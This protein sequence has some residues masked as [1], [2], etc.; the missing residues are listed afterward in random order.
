VRRV[1][2]LL[3]ALLAT[4]AFIVA[5][6]TPAGAGQPPA[7]TVTRLAETIPNYFVA[8]PR[9]S[10]P[11]ASHNSFIRVAAD[12]ARNLFFELD[13]D[14]CAVSS[15]FKTNA[16]AYDLSTYRVVA[17][18][19]VDG[20]P[21]GTKAA[22]GA[23]LRYQPSAGAGDG[24]G[25][26]VAVDPVDRL[27][28][29]TASDNSITN[30]APPQV[31]VYSEDT[32]ELLD[33]WDLPAGAPTKLAG[34]SWYAPG[35][36]LVV[37]TAWDTQ[38]RAHPDG[39]VQVFDYHI[40]TTMKR[41]GA[42]TPR[43]SVGVNGCV[44][45]IYTEMSSVDAH[46]SERSLAL[47]VPCELGYSGQAG[48]TSS[49]VLATRQGV[50]TVK[51]GA[52][53]ADGTPCPGPWV[54]PVGGPAGDSVAVAPA[55]FQG[56]K[57]DPASDRAFAPNNA[58]TTGITTLVYDGRI[59]EFLG[60]TSIGTVDDL[61][62]ASLGLDTETGRLYGAGWSGLTLVD[63][64]RTPPAAG[65]VY[66]K[67]N[68][69]PQRIDVLAVPPGPGHPYTRV[70]VPFSDCATSAS[71]GCAF[72]KVAVFA[73][74]FPLTSDPPPSALDASTYGGPIEGREVTRS[75]SG[76][77]AGYGVHTDW[78]GSAN[79]ALGNATA[80]QDEVERHDLPFGAGNRDLL[81][82]NVDHIGLEDGGAKGSAAALADGQGS[83]AA[84][85]KKRTGRIWPYPVAACGFPGLVGH[86]EVTGLQDGEDSHK[87]APV[88]HSEDT[89]AA[90]AHVVC[91]EVHPH[92][93]A[94]A[95]AYHQGGTFTA[96]NG[97]AV[98][99]ARA[100]TTATV[101][102]PVGAAG[103][104]TDVT[105]TV[106]GLRIDL[107]DIGEITIGELTHH[108]RATATGRPGGA[109]TERTQPKLRDV[110]VTV[111]GTRVPL[112]MDGC[113][114]Y[115][116]V[117]DRINAT[118]PAYLKIFQPQPDPV[119]AK[120]SPGGYTSA[121]QS[122]PSAIYGDMQF[123]QMTPAE[124][125]ILPA[126]RIVVYNDGD[127]GSR[128]VVDLAGVLADAQQGV[129]PLPEF[130]H[131]DP[132]HPPVDVVKARDYA[133]P[134]P[135]AGF[136]MPGGDGT[137]APP[138]VAQASGGNALVRAF[139]GFAFLLRSPGELVSMLALLVLFLGPLLLMARR[140]LW[141]RDLVTE[142]P[143]AASTI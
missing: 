42:P 121:I 61:N 52:K 34:L 6:V 59:G 105:A 101:T 138:Y 123:N 35:D 77:A 15:G 68:G 56:F 1:R 40:P 57:F 26:T 94:D 67:Y 85:Y 16:V 2:S 33:V 9:P 38:G 133:V 140:R 41:M 137:S 36:E 7:G 80:N 29:L 125:A 97:G 129:T 93:V 90:E 14:P 19:C 46:R 132:A 143:G 141:T 111:L 76:S 12:P 55:T 142:V 102:A 48:H 96:P 20:L 130:G 75:Y 53:H 88:S 135:E 82:G 50:V 51:L 95:D 43:W 58:L 66:P 21:V 39:A 126:L 92:R 100:E 83:T 104:V 124:A 47:Y 4:G 28:F 114:D 8:H 62:G 27:L 74:R 65:V 70:L 98:Y 108:A 119:L 10:D 11:G 113:A 31:A 5:P 44:G 69:N 79:A 110:S 17:S 127:A 3:T 91:D 120:G 86:D 23:A 25:A 45:K 78:V 139:R 13:H 72:V 87:P 99:V 128:L 109:R 103:V 107:G 63:G 71:R 136:R 89:R 18:G 117:I 134:A 106:Q 32:L 22:S 64:R 116:Q 37:L 122:D 73:D 24:Y 30:T 112:C 81:L 131:Y 118:F 49:S 60:R 54:C 115:Q 84:E